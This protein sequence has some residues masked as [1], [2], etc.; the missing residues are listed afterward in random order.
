MK[1]Y[2]LFSLFL[3]GLLLFLPA[4]AIASGQHEHDKKQ[5]HE[6]GQSSHIN[7]KMASEVGIET[8]LASLKVL[9]ETVIVYGNLVMG[10]EQLS[11][12]R[13]RYSGL[14]KSVALLR[15]GKCIC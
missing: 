1:H 14:V 6:V 12:V 4:F 8:A 9:N 7:E 11:H 5:S 2:T 10:P 15:S 13:A 3:S